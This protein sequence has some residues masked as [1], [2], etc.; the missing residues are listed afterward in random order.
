[1][2][3]WLCIHVSS[4]FVVLAEPRRREI[5]NVLLDGEVS[6]G[7]LV[8]RLGL[9]QPGVSKHLRVM[10]EAGMVVA[11]VERQHRLYRL[12]PGPLREMDE[13]LAPYRRHWATTL[14]RLDEHLTKTRAA[15][16]P[17]AESGDRA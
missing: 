15:R 14:D 2:P 4:P 12:D 13:W 9:S 5:L 16:P 11:R 8:A 3:T 1:M 6:V 17:I 7:Q 10:R